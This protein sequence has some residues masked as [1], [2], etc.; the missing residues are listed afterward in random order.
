MPSL[1]VYENWFDCVRLGSDPDTAVVSA[2]FFGTNGNILPSV[3]AKSPLLLKP[4]RWSLTRTTI[5]RIW[6]QN[7]FLKKALDILAAL[8]F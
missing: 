4:G 7:I 2:L 5:F 3:T 6:K 8:Y 1:K